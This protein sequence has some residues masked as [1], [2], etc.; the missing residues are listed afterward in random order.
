MQRVIAEADLSATGARISSMRKDSGLTN[1]QVSES[2]GISVQVFAKWQKGKGLPTLVHA[3]LLARLLG[4][5]VEEMVVL[6]EGEK[7]DE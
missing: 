3:I 1:A 2:L 4:S 7:G 6:M 5:T